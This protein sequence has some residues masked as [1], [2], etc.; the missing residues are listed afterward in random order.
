MKLELEGLTNGGNNILN[1]IEKYHSTRLDLLLKMEQ[2]QKVSDK[3]NEDTIT[4]HSV[5]SSITVG[6]DD[7]DDDGDEPD[8]PINSCLSELDSLLE[9]LDERQ[10]NRLWLWAS[11]IQASCA[12]MYRLL[13]SMI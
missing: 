6:D 2:Q 12:G 9:L 1:A 13:K 3:N 8:E 10:Q 4:V 5:N 7:D 11:E